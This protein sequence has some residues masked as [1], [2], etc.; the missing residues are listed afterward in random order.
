MQDLMQQQIDFTFAHTRPNNR[1]MKKL[2]CFSE[3]DDIAILNRN[4][5]TAL[6]GEKLAAIQ[7]RLDNLESKIILVQP[8]GRS[9]LPRKLSTILECEGESSLRD[10]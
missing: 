9:S 5:E 7:K 3:H 1:H 2:Q 8:R 6:L 4:Y 10:V